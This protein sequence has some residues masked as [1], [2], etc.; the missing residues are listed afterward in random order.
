MQTLNFPRTEQNRTEFILTNCDIQYREK[1]K[2]VN[3]HNE[4]ITHSNVYND[5]CDYLTREDKTTL[6]ILT[7][8]PVLK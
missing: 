2:H 4:C 5:N 3:D 7:P 6:V 1:I 8:G